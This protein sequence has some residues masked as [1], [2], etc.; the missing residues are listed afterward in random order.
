[1]RG[2]LVIWKSAI[3]M[4]KQLKS[5]R[6]LFEQAQRLIFKWTLEITDVEHLN[7][8][9]NLAAPGSINDLLAGIDE[10]NKIPINNPRYGEAQRQAYKWRQQIQTIEDKPL[11]DDANALAAGNKTEDLLAAIDTA[12]QISSGR[13]L[14]PTALKQ[15]REWSSIVE[16]LQDRPLLQQAQSY[17]RSNNVDNL[18]TAISIARQI[19]KGRALYDE[20]SSQIAAWRTLIRQLEASTA[21]NS[22]EEVIVEDSNTE[23]NI[24]IVETRLPKSQKSAPNPVQSEDSDAIASTN[25]RN[26]YSI[27]N[28]GTVENLSQAIKT[29]SSIP[30]SSSVKAEATEA[31]NNWSE[32]LYAIAQSQAESNV[33]LAIAT[34][35]KIPKSSAIYPTVQSQIKEWNK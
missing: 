29:A 31:I 33:K 20:A 2:R 9:R 16:T 18:R 35:K 10:V 22:A 26:A 24:E 4:A 19:T 32:Q 3:A 15:I 6:P 21:N 17:A 30:T 1:M 13:A 11:L 12:K 25:L 5:E 27:A 14:Y 8:G 28:G 23:T 34:A 7:E